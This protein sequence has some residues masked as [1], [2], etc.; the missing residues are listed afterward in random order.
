MSKVCN[1]T[2]RLIG[3]L[4]CRFYKHSSQNTLLKLYKSFI[5][6]HLEYATAAWDP[7]LIKDVTELEEVQKFALRVCTKTWSANYDSLLTQT[8]L[9][10]LQTRRQRA[11]LCSLFN[12]VKENIHFPDPPL[13][14][15]EQPYSIR[16]SNELSILPLKFRSSQFGHSF[17]PSAIDNWNTLPSE[18]QT[19]SNISTFKHALL[20]QF[21]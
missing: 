17:F 1:K 18:L 2:R 16:S 9:P 19:I 13:E 3:L 5:R 20:S 4:Y 11:K 6:P 14:I 7:Y 15:R 8:N 12:I 21:T 10:S